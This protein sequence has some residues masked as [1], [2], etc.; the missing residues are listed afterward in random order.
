MLSI[1]AGELAKGAF[2]HGF[3][4]YGVDIWEGS[5]ATC[6]RFGVT[7]FGMDNPR[8]EERIERVVFRHSGQGGFWCVLGLTLCDAGHFMMPPDVSFGPIKWGAGAVVYG[9]LEGLAGVQD[10]GVAFDRARIAPRWAAAGEREA[11][12]TARHE[13]S[14]GYVTYRYT[15]EGETLHIVFT[16]SAQETELHVL[17]PRDSSAASAR[18][19]GD[20]VELRTEQ[21]EDSLYICASAQG[22]GPHYFTVK[23]E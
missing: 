17:L 1:V 9:L 7:I 2:E 19:D 21:V 8:P 16:G 3:E 10:A 23:L 6:D 13:A 5:N 20:E 22:P 11:R 18:L 12:A 4:D 14:D 15:A